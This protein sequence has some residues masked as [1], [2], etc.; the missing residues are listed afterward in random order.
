MHTPLPTTVVVQEPPNARGR[1]HRNQCVIKR[2]SCGVEAGVA[3]EKEPA[4]HEKCMK[5]RAE[6]PDSSTAVTHESG[7]SA[8]AAE[9]FLLRFK[10]FRHGRVSLPLL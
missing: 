6:S 2:Y 7:D 10:M 1:R 4:A 8:L 3:P 9:T 5:I